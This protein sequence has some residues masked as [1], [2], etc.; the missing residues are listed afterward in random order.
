MLEQ[1]PIVPANAYNGTT[2][3]IYVRVEENAN[4]SAFGTTT[5]SLT[6]NPSPSISDILVE[7]CSEDSFSVTPVTAGVDFVPTGTT[8][9]WT[10]S[11]SAGITGAADQAVPQTS[12]S[13]SLTNTTDATTL[14]TYTV[15]A[16]TGATLTFVPIHLILMLLLILSQVFPTFHHPFVPVKSLQ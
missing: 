1:R 14:V 8:Y 9:T 12:I 16:S 5:F 6:V 10:V 4:P 11:A 15:T 2:E 7:I 13:Q 3:T